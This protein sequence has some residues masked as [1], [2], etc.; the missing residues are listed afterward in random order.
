[1]T[2][3]GSADA[4][5]ARDVIYVL[6]AS[7]A[8]VTTLAFAKAEL[9]R[10][11]NRLEESQRFQVIIARRFADSATLDRYPVR[12]QAATPAAKA[13][14]G[15]FLDSIQAGGKAAPLDALRDALSHKPDLVLLLTAN[16]RRSGPAS[17]DPWHSDAVP[18]IQL[19]REVAADIAPTLAELDA[20]NP[21]RDSVLSSAPAQRV[22]VIK[23]VQ[24]VDEDPTGLLPQIAQ[25]HGDGL[26][27]YRV[28]TLDE[29]ARLEGKPR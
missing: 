1:V 17:T 19:R 10:S 9:Q 18:S 22:S 16:F 21:V 14:V 4:T 25:R 13:K 15:T 2:F 23:A 12:P 28:L 3:A 27:S 5:R 29:I 6:D 11:I 8:M 24:F 20:L 7:G 26:G